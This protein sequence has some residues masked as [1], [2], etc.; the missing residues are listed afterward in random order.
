MTSQPTLYGLTPENCCKKDHGSEKVANALL[1]IPYLKYA[2]D[3][4]ISV[5]SCDGTRLETRSLPPLG[6]LNGACK[7]DTEKPHVDPRF[8]EPPPNDICLT[9]DGVSTYYESKVVLFK[10]RS[11]ELILRQDCYSFNCLQNVLTNNPGKTQANLTALLADGTLVERPYL[12][13]LLW[14][15][16]DSHNLEMDLVVF[17]DVGVLRMI[18]A[19][20]TPRSAQSIALI[21]ASLSQFST[22]GKMVYKERRSATVAHQKVSLF[23]LRDIPALADRMF[24][25]PV[26]STDIV[27]KSVRPD[28]SLW[29]EIDK[30][31][32]I[33][34]LG[35]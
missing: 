14:R 31:R 13:M 33:A 32:I 2:E 11:T 10:G 23:P 9:R 12:L 3:N 29:Q 20:A 21:D 24:A 8:V 7:F 1:P 16:D 5:P 18:A 26:K 35:V 22:T 30:A 25:F 28:I 17:T 19:A 4:V 6:T 34:G 15:T 27:L